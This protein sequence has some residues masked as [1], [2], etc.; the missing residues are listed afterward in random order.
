MVVVKP[1][2][3][4]QH[5]HFNQIRGATLNGRVLGNAF[6]CLPHV[7]ILA[8]EIGQGGPDP[9]WGEHHSYLAHESK[10]GLTLNEGHQ[11]VL[12]VPSYDGVA[13]P[14]PYR[15]SRFDA[16][17]ALFDSYSTGDPSAT[18]SS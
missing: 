8:T 6:G 9:I 3:Y 1:G 13:F 7:A 12:M 4:P 5:G 17:T 10:T 2:L 11:S 16:W 18:L 15:G 14:M